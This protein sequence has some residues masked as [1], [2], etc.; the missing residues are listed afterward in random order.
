MSLRFV[1]TRAGLALLIV[2]AI[3]FVTAAFPLRLLL[4]E[5]Y[6]AMARELVGVSPV[7]LT[8]VSMLLATRVMDRRR[9]P[10]MA[11]SWGREKWL[12][13]GL[14]VL[15]A[16]LIPLQ[17]GA[18]W[19]FERR[20]TDRQAMQLQ[21]VQQRLALVRSQ[22]PVPQNT[23]VSQPAAN[24]GQTLLPARKF[25]LDQLQ[26]VENGLKRLQGQAGQRRF[27]LV[28][29]SLRVCGIAAVLVWLLNGFLKKLL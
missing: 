20:T 22:T 26:R 17:M 24:P 28:V 18:S 3:R 25:E 19:L 13:R 29:E 6:L 10:G 27:A 15:F 21:A 14:L 5:W 16:L 7:L 11:P 4:P 23:A 1:I 12:L 2:A 9:K 8:A